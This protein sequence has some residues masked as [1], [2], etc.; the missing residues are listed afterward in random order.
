MNF[1]PRRMT[2]FTTKDEFSI[3]KKPFRKMTKNNEFNKRIRFLTKYLKFNQI[4]EF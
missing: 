4:F 1:E 2:F 3:Q